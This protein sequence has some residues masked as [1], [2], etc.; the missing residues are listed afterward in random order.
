M[1]CNNRLQMDVSSPPVDFAF[2][3]HLAFP[4][5]KRK[6]NL[7]GLKNEILSIIEGVRPA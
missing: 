3:F 1:L 5:G 6:V 2:E 4:P 7:K